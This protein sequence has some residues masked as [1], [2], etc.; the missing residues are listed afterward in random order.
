[1]GQTRQKNILE[2]CIIEQNLLAAKYLKQVVG[3]D[4]SVREVTL[5]DLTKGDP[6]PHIPLVFLV[7]ICGAA[8]PVVPLLRRIAARFPTARCL[9]LAQGQSDQE[10]GRLL[11]YGIHGHL[12]HEEVDGALLPALHAVAEGGMWFPRAE[13]RSFVEHT[14]AAF[15]SR[16]RVRESMTPREIEILEL[17]RRRLSNVEIA[18]ILKI[19]ESTVKFH[20]SNIFSKLRVSNRRDLVEKEYDRALWGKLLV[21][22]P[23]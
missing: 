12:T 22:A 21:P 18:E 4:R 11:W 1:M 7:D 20:L 23:A 19:R 3:K 14:S 6:V 9:V 16:S 5:E 13:L 17:A 15:G 8:S 10:A 2:I